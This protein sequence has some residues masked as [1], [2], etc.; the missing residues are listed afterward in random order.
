VGGALLVVLRDWFPVLSEKPKTMATKKKAVARNIIEAAQQAGTFKTFLAALDRANLTQTIANKGPFTVFA[1]TDDAFQAVD[2]NLLDELM[3]EGNENRLQRILKH[4]VVRGRLA[5][6]KVRTRE[7]L[8][9]MAGG[10]VRVRE[11]KGQTYLGDATLVQTDVEAGNGIIH[12]ID[13]VLL[14][15]DA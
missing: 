13:A 9:P 11:Q 4:H 12:I 6:P 7:M 10:N 5:G 8:R 15:Q 14:P 1:P 3:A 2:A